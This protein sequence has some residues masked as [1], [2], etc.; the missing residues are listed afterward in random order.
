MTE[1]VNN[2][3]EKELLKALHESCKKVDAKTACASLKENKDWDNCSFY[4]VYGSENATKED[5][6]GH[7]AETLFGPKDDN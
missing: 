4:I 6:L 7:L 1:N 5:I 2:L 3:K